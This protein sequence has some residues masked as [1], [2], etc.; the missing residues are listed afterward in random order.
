MRSALI[1]DVRAL[2]IRRALHWAALLALILL[3][4]LEW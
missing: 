4:S 3:L 2:L 1:P